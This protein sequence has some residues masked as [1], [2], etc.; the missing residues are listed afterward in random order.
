MKTANFVKTKDF[1]I[2][3]AIK[4]G[5]SQFFKNLSYNLKA[6]F[7]GVVFGLIFTVV[8]IV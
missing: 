2:R 5:F 4:F 8:P 3:Q 6:I 7:L 1:S